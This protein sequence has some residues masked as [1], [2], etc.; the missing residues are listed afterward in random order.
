M[1][2]GPRDWDGARYDRL[3]DPQAYDIPSGRTRQD[4]NL[5]QDRTDLLRP[6]D[7]T[8]RPS[9]FSKILAVAAAT[10]DFGQPVALMLLGMLLYVPDADDPWGIV[11]RLLAAVPPGSYLAV[12]HGASDI[13]PQRSAPFADTFNEHSATPLTLRTRAE[14][15]RFFDGTEL[16]EP[17]VVQIHRWRVS[18]G[19]AGYNEN[20]IAYC[21][22]GR[23]P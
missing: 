10:L 5:R 21:G 9:L 13:D 6:E 12:S 15:T 11:A 20:L 22:L 17:G 23:K 8:S 4:A 18:P 16:L 1:S 7:I 19:T 2:T 3:A 14:I